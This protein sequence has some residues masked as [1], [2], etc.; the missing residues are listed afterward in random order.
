[1]YLKKL[2]TGDGAW[3]TRKTVLGSYLNIIYHLLCLPPR[4]QEKAAAA[5]A[6]IL[7]KACT[8]SLRKWSKILWLLHSITPAVAGS[9]EMFTWVQHA[10]KRAAGRHIQLTKDVHKELEVWREL[11]CTL[12]IRPTHHRELNP[13]PP[14]GLVLPMHRGQEWEGYAETQRANNLFGVPTF[15]SQPSHAWCLPPTP[16]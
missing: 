11:V 1:M 12:S 13:P 6:A 5:L 15:T 14:H 8:T 7:R 10:L 16:L 2:G 9:R 4:Q 3:S